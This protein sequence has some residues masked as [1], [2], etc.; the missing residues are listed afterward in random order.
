MSD[1]DRGQLLLSLFS[2]TM[3]EDPHIRAAAYRALSNF[4]PEDSIISCLLNGMS[5][6][7]PLVRKAAGSSLIKFGYMFHTV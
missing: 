6:E 1:S 5:D 2:H 3:S 7:N 4:D